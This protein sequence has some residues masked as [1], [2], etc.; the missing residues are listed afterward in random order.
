VHVHLLDALSVCSDFPDKSRMIRKV[1]DFLRRTQIYGAFWFDKWH[2]SPY[3]TTAHAIITALDVASEL[4]GDGIT[5]LVQTQRPDGSWGA[6]QGTAEETAYA[7]QALTAY[8]RRGGKV[9]PT[10][11]QQGLAYLEKSVEKHSSSYPLLWVSK[12][13][14]SP[15][16]V[17]HSA[18]LGAML[19]THEALGV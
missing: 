16:W 6:L 2:T 4:I 12:T 11:L 1:I 13:L 17:V 15:K 5:W 3:Y 9:L 18:V 14:Y 8:K 10:T 19:M 7:L